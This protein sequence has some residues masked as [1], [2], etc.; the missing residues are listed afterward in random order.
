MGGH[1]HAH[2][3]IRGQKQFKETRD[4]PGLKSG[5]AIADW[6]CLPYIDL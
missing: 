1:T 5:Q 3:D 6:L 4:G 2:T